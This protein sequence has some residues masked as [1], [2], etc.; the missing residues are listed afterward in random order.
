MPIFL[1]PNNLK[2]DDRKEVGIIRTHKESCRAVR[3]SCSDYSEYILRAVRKAWMFHLPK[4]WYQKYTGE[5]VTGVPV[6]AHGYY[7]EHNAFV[8]EYLKRLLPRERSKLRW[9]RD[10]FALI[11]TELVPV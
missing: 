5:G 4:P 11:N 10:L 8:F 2:C 1:K 9:Y 7:R 3:D 6:T